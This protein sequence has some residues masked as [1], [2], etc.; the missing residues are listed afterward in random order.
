MEVP[1]LLTL[2]GFG[3]TIALFLIKMWNTNLKFRE[4]QEDSANKFKIEQE[5]NY[6]QFT[7]TTNLRLAALEKELVALRESIVTNRNDIMRTY[8]KYKDETVR[9]TAEFRRETKDALIENK[10]E[11]QDIKTVLTGM[12][13][14]L[15]II[16]GKLSTKKERDDFRTNGF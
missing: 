9:H 2:I 12:K 13:E 15:D 7:V 8:E 6:I 10:T 11:H 14:N 4:Q 1:I 5:K 3:I 16:R